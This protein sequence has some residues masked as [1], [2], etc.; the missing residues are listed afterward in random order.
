MSDFG[1]SCGSLL[2]ELRF[3]GISIR[4]DGKLLHLN[5]L[6]ELSHDLVEPANRFKDEL[7]KQIDAEDYAIEAAIV[8]ARRSAEPCGKCVFFN[9]GSCIVHALPTNPT[10]DVNCTDFARWH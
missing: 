1:A 2:D 9:A 5:A 6:E 8:A 3:R 4:H 10:A 7:R